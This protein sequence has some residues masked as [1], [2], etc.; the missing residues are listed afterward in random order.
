VTLLASGACRGLRLMHRLLEAESRKVAAALRVKTPERRFV[1]L[2]LS[3]QLC[4][5][6]DVPVRD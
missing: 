2:P 3:R 5:H 6:F 4:V 1:L